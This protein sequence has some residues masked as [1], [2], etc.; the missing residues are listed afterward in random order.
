MLKKIL[1]G[2]AVLAVLMVAAFF[3]MNNRNRTLS[4]PGNVALTN[5]DL[6]ISITYSRPSVRGRL[7]FG[8]TE[9]GALQPYGAYWR[10]GANEATE[11]TLNKDV[12]F[13]D[14]SL[15]AGTYMIYAMPEEGGFEIIAN[16]ELGRWGYFEPDH[17]LDILKTKIA[18][19]KTPTPVEQ[20][21]I[22]LQPI[23]NGINVVFEWSDLHWTIP[24]TN[25]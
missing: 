15:K 24:I 22:S 21:T 8:T 10:L 2:V 25:P 9:Q 19:E 6:T 3:Y 17:T 16:T 1:I 5:G 23:E 18:S 7:I 20:Y 14:Q 11:I 13:N 4:P 12:K